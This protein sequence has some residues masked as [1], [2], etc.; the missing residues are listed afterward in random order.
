[1]INQQLELLKKNNKQ[2]ELFQIIFHIFFHTDFYNTDQTSSDQPAK[3]HKTIEP[4]E[5]IRTMHS[6]DIQIINISKLTKW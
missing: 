4:V 3:N 1:M 2:I 6:Y 5:T